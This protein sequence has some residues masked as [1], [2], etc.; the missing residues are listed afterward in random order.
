MF[1][2]LLEKQM[3]QLSVIALAAL[4]CAS[5]PHGLRGQTK[6][7]L[8]SKGSG[9]PVLL[10]ND[11]YDTLSVN[12]I[13]QWYSNNGSMSHNPTTDGPGLLWPRTGWPGSV[14]PR[15]MFTE[16][17]VFSGVVDGQIRA[18]GATYRYGMQA[19]PILA[20]GQ[21]ADPADPVHRIYKARRLS[22][23]AFDAL[24]VALRDQLR[25]DFTEWP[26]TLGAPW[27]DSNHNDVYDPDFD[28]WLVDSTTSDK[29]L[30]IGDEMLWFVSNDMDSV[31]TKNLYGSA[32]MGV[33]VQTLAWAFERSGTLA[34]TVFQKHTVI[35]KSAK[36]IDGMVFG[37]WA[38]PDLGYAGDD[39]VGTD[40]AR[41]MIYDYNCF[42]RDGIYSNPPASG[43]VLLQGPVAPDS[44]AIAKWNFADRA[45]WKN[46]RLTASHFYYG[47]DAVY[48][49]PELGSPRGAQQLRNNLTGLVYGGYP[50][51]DPITQLKTP[52][53][54][55]GDPVTHKG[56]ITATN[57]PD[58]DYRSLMATGAVTM[59]PGDTQEVVFAE[60][61]A[62]GGSVPEDIIALRRAADE[63]RQWYAVQPY[64]VEIPTSTFASDFPEPDK[65]RVTVR[66][67]V[68]GAVSATG[69][70]FLK[71]GTF[72]EAIP[73]FDDGQHD[74]GGAGDGNYAGMITRNSRSPFGVR[75]V[76]RVRY[77]NGAEA[78]WPSNPCLPLS[79][80]MR[81]SLRTVESDHRNFD[82]VANPGENIRMSVNLTNESPFP[83][84]TF[85]IRNDGF[86]PLAPPEIVCNWYVPPGETSYRIYGMS[87]PTSYFTFD[88]PPSAADGEVFRLPV[89][90]VDTLNECW[91]DTLTVAARAFAEEPF[92]SLTV[93]V[94]GP[95]TGTLGW[96]L[97]SRAALQNHTYRITMQSDTIYHSGTLTIEDLST[98][99][100]RALKL[101]F[102]DYLAHASPL[103]DGWKI[104]MGTALQGY[105]YT[106][107]G[108]LIPSTGARI[109]SAPP[110]ASYL[111]ENSGFEYGV[112]FFGTKLQ[113]YE[114]VPV[115]IVFSSSATQKAYLYLRG[116]T[117]NYGCTGYFDVPMRAYDIS[118]SA[119]P[120]QLNL[121]FVEQNG[122]PR[123]NNTWDPA[124]V[125][126]RESLFVLGST[127]SP[128]PDPVLMTYTINAHAVK[129]DI[130][131]AG[132]YSRKSDTTRIPEGATV[133][134]FPQIPVTKRDTFLLNP[135]GLVSNFRPVADAGA[136]FIGHSYP[137]PLDMRNGAAAATNPLN[138]RSAGSYTI[139][140]HDLL[141]RQAA[142]IFEGLLDPGR[143]AF[144][145]TLPARLPAGIYRIVATGA[146]GSASVPMLV[147]R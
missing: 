140:V 87:D 135:L 7:H 17:L 81:A 23:P 75:C 36:T 53:V 38:D 47:A 6:G 33:E 26:S 142:T 129:M 19:G 49:D 61:V 31:R 43:I 24:P 52:F 104:T 136:F 56:W 15:L 30:F 5:L 84:G 115:R 110:I 83:L 106:E 67:V 34:N 20:N 130:Q 88:V 99:E 121:A 144:T 92:D 143:H 112:L 58:A 91:C 74:D 138:V 93:H 128:T 55:A 71:D 42:A 85:T 76:L 70:M 124:D 44:N 147:L 41:D 14:R 97:A 1:I 21:P 69:A 9:A 29:P 35:N 40:T 73:L 132:W 3:R 2:A 8:A 89:R 66:A 78:D 60:I 96:R 79:G 57:F 51:I 95:G 114:Y 122:G 72:L 82:H 11:A 48:A 126:D 37:R 65:T 120:R 133:T 101:P 116:G 13:L 4:L 137:N 77:P 108:S 123:N 12:N 25:R 125:T 117:P 98:R 18:G 109:V 94:A 141:G 32:P 22:K 45:G 127:Y 28:R 102:P 118:D 100:V 134:I 145:F 68:P 119:A 103:I 113:W 105:I 59:A 86:M 54:F 64:Q 90:I 107:R 146:A 62:D 46:L 50:I 16:G 39:F 111:N 63:V 27:M 139:T 131:Y 80:T 10:T